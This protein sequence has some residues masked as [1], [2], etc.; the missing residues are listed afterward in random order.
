VQ[1][2]TLRPWPPVLPA[3]EDTYQEFVAGTIPVTRLVT[4]SHEVLVLVRVEHEWG[5]LRAFD[6]YLDAIR[7]RRCRP[8]GT[9]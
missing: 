5:I 8:E 4:D 9:G 6:E 1:L 7:E 2:P 3:G